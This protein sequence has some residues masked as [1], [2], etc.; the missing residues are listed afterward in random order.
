[1]NKTKSTTISLR[2]KPDELA[3]IEKQAFESD[4]SRNAYILKCALDNSSAPLPPELLCRLTTIKTFL[5]MPLEDMDEDI[6]NNYKMEVKKLCRL[7][8]KL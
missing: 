6:K 4:I 1:M 8:L 2:L 5:S 3:Y 7:L